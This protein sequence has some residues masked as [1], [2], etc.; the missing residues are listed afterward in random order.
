MTRGIDQP[1]TVIGAPSL[2]REKQP[3]LEAKIN[4]CTCIVT[5]EVPCTLHDHFVLFNRT[6]VYCCLI[7]EEF[8]RHGVRPVLGFCFTWKA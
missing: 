7:S 8:D 1:S 6:P 2:G 3:K 5:V 4:C